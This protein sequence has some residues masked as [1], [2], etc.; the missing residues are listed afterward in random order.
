[1]GMQDTTEEVRLHVL[2]GL[3]SAACC[4]ARQTYMFPNVVI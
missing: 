1:M 3:L 2:F 4:P